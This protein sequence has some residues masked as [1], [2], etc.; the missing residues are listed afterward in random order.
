MG[1]QTPLPYALR[2][3]LGDNLVPRWGRHM[4]H[5]VR[6]DNLVERAISEWQLVS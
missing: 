6:D 4:L 5:Y 1:S 2:A 3:I